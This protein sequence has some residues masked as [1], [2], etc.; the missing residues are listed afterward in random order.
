VLG[1]MLI[2]QAII[3]HISGAAS[4]VNWASLSIIAFNQSVT[5][6]ISVLW[7]IGPKF[8]FIAARP[9]IKSL[10]VISYLIIGV[11]CYFSCAAFFTI[12][13][14]SHPSLP[15]PTAIGPLVASAVLSLQPLSSFLVIAVLTDLRVMRGKKDNIVS[16]LIDGLI[17]AMAAAATQMIISS[18]VSVLVGSKQFAPVL[19]AVLPAS[20]ARVFDAFGFSEFSV[21]VACIGL[22]VGFVVPATAANALALSL[23][24]DVSGS[25]RIAALDSA[26]A[27][28]LPPRAII[29]VAEE[30]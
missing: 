21:V 22:I 2:G 7:A 11:F 26:A 4:F 13:F 1:V 19:D 9:A 17:A 15:L 24:V 20:L 6:S 30:Q 29:N 23:V 27:L 14:L 25:P 8:N 18:L 5:Q 28:R 10:P 16:R 3:F 12:I